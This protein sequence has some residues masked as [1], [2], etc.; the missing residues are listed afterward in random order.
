MYTIG[1]GKLSQL[2]VWSSMNTNQPDALSYVLENGRSCGAQ[3]F[4][5]ILPWKKF[6]NIDRKSV[7]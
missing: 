1:K 5:D 6:E 4:G 3:V 2:N 7:V